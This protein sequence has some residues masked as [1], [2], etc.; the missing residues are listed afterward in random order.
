MT[1]ALAL[2]LLIALYIAGNASLDEPAVQ[3]AIARLALAVARMVARLTFVAPIPLPQRSR[4]RTVQ[5]GA[6]A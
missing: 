6:L 2:I 3:R 1:A 5:T 4:P